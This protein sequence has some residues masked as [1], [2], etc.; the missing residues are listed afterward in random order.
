ML[1]ASHR[2]G[3]TSRAY[4]PQPS[5]IERTLSIIAGERGVRSVGGEEVSYRTYRERLG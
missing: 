4:A 1:A 3:P 5:A 2:H